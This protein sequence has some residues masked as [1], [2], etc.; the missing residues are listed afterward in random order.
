MPR[1]SAAA[2]NV[3]RPPT[4]TPPPK[5]PVELTP[6][7][8]E[9]WRT[10]TESLPHDWFPVCARPLLIELCR[11]IVEARFIAKQIEKFGRP[12]KL[13]A[14]YDR[15]LAIANRESKI[16]IALSRSLRLTNQ[17]RYAPHTAESKRKAEAANAGSEPWAYVP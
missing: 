12:K 10:I 3:I 16:I 9:V 1:K 7:Q 13:L 4:F 11:H 6:E 15:W 17:S 14:E 2:L 5:P 8:A